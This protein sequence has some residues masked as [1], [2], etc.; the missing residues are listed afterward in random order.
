MPGRSEFTL[1][2]RIAAGEL[3]LLA[4]PTSRQAQ[5]AEMPGPG[6]C[7]YSRAP[8]MVPIPV[9]RCR[10]TARAV[11]PNGQPGAGEW[12]RLR[13]FIPAKPELV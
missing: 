9:R 13:R 11:N 2:D 5:L 4:R 1:P 12:R 3:R 7:F 6:C 10:R 8:H